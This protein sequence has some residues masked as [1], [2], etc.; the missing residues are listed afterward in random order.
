MSESLTTLTRTAFAV[1]LGALLVAAPL[2]AS[3]QKKLYTRSYLLQDFRS[4]TTRIVLDGPED[5]CR[6]LWEDATAVWTLSPYEFCTLA[7]Y[8]ADACKEG[9][10]FLRPTESRGIVYLTLTRGASKPMTVVSIPVAGTSYRDPLLYMPAYLS[11]IQDYVEAAMSSEF[12]AYLGLRSATRGTAWGKK[13]FK[14]PSEAAKAFH[15]GDPDAAVQ[16]IIT[17]D[18]NFSSRPRHKLVIGA[19]QYE[20]YRYR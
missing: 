10:Y 2:P 16:V 3:A 9:C 18:G 7:D 15:S 20:L 6:A 19:S 17:P 8:E 14:D 4:Q 13:V 12:K 5:L 1:L 11:I